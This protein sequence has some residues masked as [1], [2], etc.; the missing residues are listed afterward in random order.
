MWSVSLVNIK[1]W[2]LNISLLKL[3]KVCMISR[4]NSGN[5][6]NLLN[7]KKAKLIVKWRQISAAALSA[8]NTVLYAQQ[9]WLF[10]NNERREIK[11]HNTSVSNILIYHLIVFYFISFFYCFYDKFCYIRSWKLLSM[12]QTYRGNQALASPL[13]DGSKAYNLDCLADYYKCI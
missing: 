3:Q 2:I 8:L 12:T 5:Y 10:R 1:L 6:F 7:E 13:T 9:R 4:I 11:W